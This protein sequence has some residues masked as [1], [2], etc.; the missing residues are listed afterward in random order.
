L[1]VRCLMFQVSGVAKNPSGGFLEFDPCKRSGELAKI[2]CKAFRL[3]SMVGIVLQETFA[4][5]Q[6]K[7]FKGPE[8]EAGGPGVGKHVSRPS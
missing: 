2:G 3:R 7:T 8:E 5:P 4:S 6:G 1:K